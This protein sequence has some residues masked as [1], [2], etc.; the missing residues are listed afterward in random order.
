MQRGAEQW[1]SGK[2][3]VPGAILL[4]AL[5]MAEAELTKALAQS[6]AVSLGQLLRPLMREELKFTVEEVV[7]LL[8]GTPAAVCQGA[9]PFADEAVQV[10]EQLQARCAREG[11]PRWPPGPAADDRA[12]ERRLALRCRMLSWCTYDDLDVPAV[13]RKDRGFPFRVA[14]GELRGVRSTASS[15]AKIARAESACMAI[16]RH[17]RQSMRAT[18]DS[19]EIGA[20]S[21][22]GRGPQSGA[23]A[24]AFLPCLIYLVCR[25]LGLQRGVKVLSREQVRELQQEVRVLGRR[26]SHT[27]PGP[28]PGA[29]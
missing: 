21:P 20:G 17:L 11:R 24:D 26:Q 25:C 16:M 15:L 1:R 10:C 9:G 2:L 13:C 5:Q 3:S 14:A 8:P 12:A 18:E 22:G 4:P 28:R 7:E 27:L 6:E 29:E 23:D 19:A